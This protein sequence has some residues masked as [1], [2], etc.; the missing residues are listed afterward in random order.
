MGWTT[1]TYRVDIHEPTHARGASFIPNA[2]ER[3]GRQAVTDDA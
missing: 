3:V 1:D 2:D